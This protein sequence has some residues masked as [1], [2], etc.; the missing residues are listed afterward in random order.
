MIRGLTEAE[1]RDLFL[2]LMGEVEAGDRY[3]SGD[4]F[5]REWLDERISRRFAGWAEFFGEFGE[6]DVAIGFVGVEVEPRLKCVP[7]TGQYSEIVAIGVRS[8]H[9]RLG[10][11]RRLLA[12]AE[13]F[14]HR[15]GA[16]CLYVAAYEGSAEAI[17][18]YVDSGFSPVAV[19][20][21]VYGPAAK[22]RIYLRKL[23]EP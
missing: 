3:D 23:L 11:G 6:R 10:H 5:H 13:Q 14:A 18:F 7:Y 21:G 8:E 16:H 15:Q 4:V 20:P 22:G 9:R 12:F 19:L 2:D 1:F 17:S